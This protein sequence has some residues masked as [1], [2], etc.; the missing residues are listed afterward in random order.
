[1]AIAH[2][3]EPTIQGQAGWR[4]IPVVVAIIE[5]VTEYYDLL[6][7]LQL[8]AEIIED[9]IDDKWHMDDAK[10]ESVH[11]WWRDI[12]KLAP[13]LDD[14]GI[15]LNKLVWELWLE[16]LPGGRQQFASE[17]P[18]NTLWTFQD[19]HVPLA[20]G[21]VLTSALKSKPQWTQRFI[22]EEPVYQDSPSDLDEERK[23]RN[24][25]GPMPCLTRIVRWSPHHYKDVLTEFLD[26]YSTAIVSVTRFLQKTE[27]RYSEEMFMQLEYAAVRDFTITMRSPLSNTCVGC[28]RILTRTV[29][30]RGLLRLFLEEALSL[31]FRYLVEPEDLSWDLHRWM[32]NCASDACNEASKDELRHMMREKFGVDDRVSEHASIRNF[33]YHQAWCWGEDLWFVAEETLKDV[34][35]EP[36]GPEIEVY[37]YALPCENGKGQ[38]T[39]CLEEFRDG[40][41]EHSLSTRACGHRFHYDC[42]HGLINGI[43]EYSNKCPLCR[44]VICERRQRRPTGVEGS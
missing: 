42:L 31:Y 6:E 15:D 10:Y 17:F 33:R 38:C 23:F 2:N 4:S 13:G 27:F 25:Q 39:I 11:Y 9:T 35:F 22:D 19:L 12:E 28:R 43:E 8:L 40:A 20:D 5:M 7:V 26:V 16:V 18:L 29:N 30:I 1:M 21:F 36:C 34:E 41:N 37:P 14:L 3:R 44:K 32:I 24:T